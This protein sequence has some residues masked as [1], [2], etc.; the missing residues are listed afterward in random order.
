MVFCHSNNRQ[1]KRASQGLMCIYIPAL[2]S[3]LK[4]FLILSSHLCYDFWFE[5]LENIYRALEDLDFGAFDIYL[6]Q[7]YSGESKPRDNVID[8]LGLH[9][10]LEIPCKLSA[11]SRRARVGYVEAEGGVSVLGRFGNHYH[12]I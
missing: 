9:L 1:K 7:I 11:P 4:A 2:S 8:G 12:V 10:D 5:F 6:N 3:A